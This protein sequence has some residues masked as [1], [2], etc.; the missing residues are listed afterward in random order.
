MQFAPGTFAKLVADQAAIST[1]K[2]FVHQ[3]LTTLDRIM[4]DDEVESHNRKAQNLLKQA[5][6]T[7]HEVDQEGVD[8]AEGSED[9]ESEEEEDEGYAPGSEDGSE[10]DSPKSQADD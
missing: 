7:L 3:A 1:A 8:E 10:R 4:F 2:T 5:Y 9:D 6:M